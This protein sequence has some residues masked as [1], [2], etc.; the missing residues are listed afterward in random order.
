[1]IVHEALSLDTSDPA[2]L[3]VRYV[4]VHDGAHSGGLVHDV[5][6][7]LLVEAAAVPWLVA[8]LAA[9]LT[10]YGYPGAETAVGRSRIHVFESGPEQAPIVHVISRRPD[11]DGG[12]S[13]LGLTR[14]AARQLVEL[15]RGS[16]RAPTVGVIG[17]A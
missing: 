1:V 12:A 9:C 2:L 4:Q 16:G 5:G 11:A 14:A 13:A 6:G 17:D 7:T 15:L 8:E 3:R 10:T